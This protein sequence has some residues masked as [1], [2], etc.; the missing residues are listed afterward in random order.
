[1]GGG[2][3]Y[4]LMLERIGEEEREYHRVGVGVGGANTSTFERRMGNGG[5]FDC[6]IPDFLSDECMR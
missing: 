1:M 4:G 3:V 5:D 6:I 2:C